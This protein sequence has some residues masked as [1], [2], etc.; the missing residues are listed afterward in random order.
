MKSGVGRSG[1]PIERSKTSRPAASASWRFRSN[2]AKRYRGK[3]CS[4]AL[5][6][7]GGMAGPTL[8]GG[9]K[10]CQGLPVGVFEG[11]FLLAEKHHST[12]QD[13]AVALQSIDVY[14]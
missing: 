5:F 6:S 12:R 13:E 9:R 7:M 8:S 10:G 11:R 14:T 3:D 2:S 4:R 1:S